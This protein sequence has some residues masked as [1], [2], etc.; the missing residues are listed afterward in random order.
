MVL[1]VLSRNY[2]CRRFIFLRSTLCRPDFFSQY[3]HAFRENVDPSLSDDFGNQSRRLPVR[4]RDVL[5]Q[6][7]NDEEK[8]STLIDFLEKSVLL[9]SNVA[10]IKLGATSLIVDPNDFV[11]ACPPGTREFPPNYL[12]PPNLIDQLERA[13]GTDPTVITHVVINPP[14]EDGR[15]LSL[16]KYRSITSK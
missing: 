16:G 6:P 9:P 2:C 5:K 4:L 3:S 7:E 8:S 10:L 13:L 1:C 11:I 15:G 14:D 12:V